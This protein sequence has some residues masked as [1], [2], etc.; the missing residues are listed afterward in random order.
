MLKSGCRRYTD[1]SRS[2]LSWPPSDAVARSLVPSLDKSRRSRFMIVTPSPRSVRII[3]Q[4]IWCSSESDVSMPTSPVHDR[5]KSGEGYHVVPPPYTGTFMP[6]KPNLV[7]HDALIVN[8]TVY[9][10]LNVEPS[11]KDESEDE[12]MPTQK[13]HSFVH[14]SGHVKTPRPSVK[15]DC[16]YYEKKMVQ[17]PVKNQDIRGNHQHYEIMTHPYPHRHVVPTTVLTRSRLVPLTAARPITTVV[18]QTKVQH[19]WPTKHSVTKA[20][21]PLRR[22]INLRPSPTHSNPQ[23]ALKDKGVIESGC[24]RHMI[25]N[26]YYLSNFEEISGGYVAFGGNPKGGKITSKGK[27]RTG[28]LDFDDVYFVKELKF[29]LF[30]VSQMYDKKNSVLFTDTKCIVMSSDFKLSDENHMLLR[31]PKENNMYN[32]DLKNIVPSG[33]LTC[34][35]AKATLDESNL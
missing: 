5:Y 34:L 19:Q 18:P 32:V 14:T 30:S 27:I 15:P 22:P 35:F 24:S 28:K 26:I 4:D 33:Y 6:S 8:E 21:S 29:N 7:F 10:I 17:K 23:H 12:P 13:A 9:T 3:L 2:S 11:P 1:D 25:G 20:H 16:D 31:V